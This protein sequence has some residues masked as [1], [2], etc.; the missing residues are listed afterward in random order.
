MALVASE[1]GFSLHWHA[2]V[3]WV[4]PGDS[5]V[6][7]SSEHFPILGRREQSESYMPG[8]GGP[9]TE[10]CQRL[11]GRDGVCRALVGQ[12]G[13]ESCASRGQLVGGSLGMHLGCWGNN[14]YLN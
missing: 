2:S 3:V 10:T 1:P 5:L 9:K 13:E 12:V 8:K 11:W 6:S 4:C 14:G 7:L